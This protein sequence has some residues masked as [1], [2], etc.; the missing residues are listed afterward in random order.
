[1]NNVFSIIKPFLLPFLIAVYPSLFHYAN[2][3]KIVRINSLGRM[4][5]FNSIIAVVVYLTIFVLNNKK[6][7]NSA[8][9]A[10]VFLVFF[11]TYGVL[12]NAILQHWGNLRHIYSL[13]IYFLIGTIITY[14]VTKINNK[15]SKKLNNNLITVFIILS[16]INI[17]RF[18]PVEIR[19]IGWQSTTAHLTTNEVSNNHHYPDIYYLVF[20]EFAGFE[21]M[22]QYWNHTGIDDFVDELSNQGFFVAEESYTT[23]R[24][25]DTLHQ[26]AMRLNF[27]IY[28]HEIDYRDI[29]FQAIKDN[30]V[31]AY[32]KQ[33]GYTTITFDDV[34]GPFGY[35][36]K[37]PIHAKI[38]F[39]D[40]PE[41]SRVNYLF[42][43]FG[44]LVVDN[45][46]LLAASRY[47]KAHNPA[48]IRH[49]NMIHFTTNKLGELSGNG[50][51]F[52]YVHLLFPHTP[53]MFDEHGNIID[54]EFHQDWNYYF[55]NY[56]YS[57]NIM[58]EMLA[59]IFSRYEPENP[60][61]IILQSDHGAR[62]HV[63]P[64][65]NFHDYPGEF[66]ALILNAV[67]LP[68]CENAPITHTMDPINTFPI[69][70]NCLFDDNLPI[71]DV[72]IDSFP[73]HQ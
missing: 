27:K 58:Q 61:V 55:G 60:P 67:Y 12:F 45:T 71:L 32:L 51:I 30:R 5:V 13:P 70:F 25:G 57:V 56:M 31:M 7:P 43:E 52:V 35:E 17:I 49:K 50:P 14:F 3:V 37:E 63:N 72:T 18:I 8:L 2:N 34:R 28:P 21:A 26:M 33:K 22:R 23:G 19:K 47:Y 9:S 62:I 16:I 42:D 48:L 40:D 10:F 15:F 4:I 46:M 24:T 1:M 39:E 73:I 66:A 68:Q 54:Q 44:S 36:T 29:H 65:E 64:S 59:N 6:A 11:N 38:N 20:D 69:I 53:F 41:I